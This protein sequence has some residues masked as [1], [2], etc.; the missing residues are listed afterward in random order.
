MYHLAVSIVGGDGALRLIDI[1]KL[2]RPSFIEKRI[3]T[4]PQGHPGDHLQKA[5]KQF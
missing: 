2:Q 4:L 3:V 1:G 5:F